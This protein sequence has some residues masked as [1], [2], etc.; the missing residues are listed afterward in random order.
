V[1]QNLSVITV[2]LYTRH[3]LHLNAQGKEHTADRV[4]A[5]IRDLFSVKK[6][7]PIA[8][9]WKEKG[10]MLSCPAVKQLPCV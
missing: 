8:L 5:M 1:Y 7:L 4:I 9:K 2:D 10:N 3:G 6:S